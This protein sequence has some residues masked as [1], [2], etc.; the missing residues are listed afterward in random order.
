MLTAS[1]SVSDMIVNRQTRDVCRG[2]MYWAAQKRLNAAGA[3][4][5]RKERFGRHQDWPEELDTVLA[6]IAYNIIHTR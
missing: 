2:V 5:V 1:L 6:I 4:E 3:P